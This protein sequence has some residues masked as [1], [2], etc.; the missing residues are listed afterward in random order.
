MDPYA[1]P[2]LPPV[3]RWSSFPATLHPPAGSS[4]ANGGVWAVALT[5]I[6]MG[7]LGLP[8]ALFGASPVAPMILLLGGAAGAAAIRL[9]RDQLA[10][11]TVCAASLAGTELTFGWGQSS[12]TD[13]GILGVSLVIPVLLAAALLPLRA[14]VLTWVF[15]AACVGLSAFQDE[16]HDALTAMLGTA[17]MLATVAAFVRISFRISRDA[18][19]RAERNELE[20]S[21]LYEELRRNAVSR[22]QLGRIIR[23]MAG[24][25]WVADAN[26]RISLAN[27]ATFAITG[28]SADE[29][30][31]RNVHE[32]VADWPD[33]APVETTILTACGEPLPILLATS[34]LYPDR[35]EE[36]NVCI[37]TDLSARKAAEQAHERALRAAIEA[38]RAKSHFLA[39]MSHELRTPLN[40]IIGYSEMLAEEA[41]EESRADNE[42]D[43]QKIR[44]SGQHL[45]TLINDVLDLS[46]IE[47]GRMEVYTESIDAGAAIREVLDAVAPMATNND[48]RLIIRGL[49]TLG[50]ITTDAVKLKQI[51]LNLLSNACKFTHEGTITVDASRD[52]DGVTVTIADQGIGMSEAQLSRVFQPFVQADDT[53]A[54]R[55]GGTGLG[56]S[57]TQK[58]V[59]MLR[60]QLEVQSRLGYGTTFKVRLPTGTVH[61]RDLAEEVVAIARENTLPVLVVDDDPSSIDLVT[62]T[63]S[64]AGVASI[65]AASGEEALALLQKQQVSAIILDVLMPGM[66]GLGLLHHIK[67]TPDLQGTP[68]IMLTMTD[69]RSAAFAMGASDYLMKPFRPQQLIDL[70]SG[71]VGGGATVLVV[72]DDDDIRALVRRTL[73]FAGFEVAEARS[74]AEALAQVQKAAP[75]MIFLDLL[76]PEMDGFEL[77]D[78]L[79]TTHPEMKIPIVVLSASDPTEAQLDHLSG[80]VHRLIRKG[81]PDALDLVAEAGRDLTTT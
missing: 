55:F 62:R 15:G 67:S 38:N 26:G 75:S 60:G 5:L 79:R 68:T 35:P 58:F 65:A 4:P 29:L 39:N 52:A 9:D 13:P 22:A 25:M 49:E 20:A 46:K 14:A 3:A 17:V 53:T 50:T 11:L 56:L 10:A 77:I 36:G 69:Q 6:A 32:L 61:E 74:G 24:P 28:F 44:A 41:R 71:N 2:S 78:R 72:D 30:V 27:D 76:M 34:A 16:H 7:I 73:T 21:R 47:A 43:L 63:L 40:A 66:G 12:H 1:P 33:G 70:V 57:I 51:V 81:A 64:R 80:A 37:A 54:R 48:N 42:A 59:E 19:D 8:A 31:G 45:L 18:I 23:S